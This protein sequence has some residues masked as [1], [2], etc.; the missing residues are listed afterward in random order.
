[1]AIEWKKAKNFLIFLKS[2]EECLNLQEAQIETGFVLQ[3]YT[4]NL[5]GFYV[6]L[7]I[8][9]LTKKIFYIGKGKKRRAEQ[10]LIDNKNNKEKN[11]FKKKEFNT[12]LKY[13]LKPII[14]IIFDSLEEEMAYKIEKKLIKR[15]YKSITNISQNENEP[16]LIK[17]QVKTL[18]KRLPTY[19]Q[20]INGVYLNNPL[21]FEILKNKNYGY[22]LF[23][24][25]KETILNLAK[26]YEICKT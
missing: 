10:H 22:E 8:N 13:R 3:D 5:K 12:F 26:E 25:A 23:C 7:L 11:I 24:S 18:L 4:K 14:K 2:Y 9:P 16:N 19:N 21:V 1:M 15:L 17:K 20:W 6:Y